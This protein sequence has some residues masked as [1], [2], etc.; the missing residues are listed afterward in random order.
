MTTTSR[1]ADAIDALVGLL[2]AAP[3]LADASIVDGPDVAGHK[4]RTVCVGWDGNPDGEGLA[5]EW[6]QAWASVGQRAKN[7]TFSVTCAVVA[8]DG[9]T[10]VRPIRD[11]AYVLLGA[12]EDA[13][14]GNP[15][16]GFPPPTIVAVTSGATF[17]EQIP[18]GR[19][20]R[21]TFQVAVQTRI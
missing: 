16:L 21:V 6:Q 10:A 15:S 20:C 9:G 11:A 17:Q 3:G 1:A 5:V 14:R 2:Q 8:W 18:E 19:L 13:L 7:E 12:V 4:K